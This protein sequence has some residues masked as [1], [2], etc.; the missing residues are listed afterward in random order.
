MH[1]NYSL[2][3][4][5]YTHTHTHTHTHTQTW[6]YQLNLGLPSIHLSDSIGKLC[7]S[8]W[9]NAHHSISKQA[10][11]NLDSIFSIYCRPVFFENGVITSKASL[12]SLRLSQDK[13]CNMWHHNTLSLT[14]A[15]PH[16]MRLSIR[17][18][19]ISVREKHSMHGHSRNTL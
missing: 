8:L 13:A 10:K 4:S 17:T 16:S 3:L 18:L 2:L 11:L 15:S 12:G 9:R 19:R 5:T 14:N 6:F 7:R 1:R